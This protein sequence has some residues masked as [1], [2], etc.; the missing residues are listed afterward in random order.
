MKESMVRNAPTPTACKN[1]IERVHAAKKESMTSSQDARTHLWGS[2][3]NAPKSSYPKPGRNTAE[4]S[5][6]NQISQW[7]WRSPARSSG[8]DTRDWENFTS[9]LHSNAS[10]SRMYS[11]T[12]DTTAA[13]ALH[14]SP[15]MILSI[16][17]GQYLCDLTRLATPS[18]LRA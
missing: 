13:T 17:H 4:L 7:S 12:F 1:I 3:K 10:Y 9:Q 8:A 11:R 6:F 16:I 14:V 5:K 15:L 2:F 18:A